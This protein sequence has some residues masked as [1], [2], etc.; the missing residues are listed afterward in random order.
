MFRN[1][2][3]L[4]SIILLSILA[5]IS[6]W[7]IIQADAEMLVGEEKL[8]IDTFEKEIIEAPTIDKTA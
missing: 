5:V 4:L 2:I 3:L 7:N 6:L 8:V 1:K